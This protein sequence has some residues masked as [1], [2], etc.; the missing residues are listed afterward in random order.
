M[1][2]PARTYRRNTMLTLWLARRSAS[3]SGCT[4][5]YIRSASRTTAWLTPGERTQSAHRGSVSSRASILISVDSGI[6]LTWATPPSLRVL[7]QTVR[8]YR[9]IDAAVRIRRRPSS[10]LGRRLGLI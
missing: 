9:D 6:I 10:G 1:R 8:G 2:Y 3:W 5:G 7:P 4:D